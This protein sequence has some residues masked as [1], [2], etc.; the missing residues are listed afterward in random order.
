[1]LKDD[2]NKLA[3]ANK[4]SGLEKI[5][6]V[7]LLTDPFTIEDGLLTPTMKI[8]RN[9]ATKRFAEDIKR[10]YTLPLK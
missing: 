4:F 8:K 6:Q 10:L 7:H 5:K 9:E 2:F 1:M 3:V